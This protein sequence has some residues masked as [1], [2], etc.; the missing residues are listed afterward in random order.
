ML[1]LFPDQLLVKAV[2]EITRNEKAFDR[3]LTKETHMLPLQSHLMNLTESLIFLHGSRLN[4][5]NRVRKVKARPLL[6]KRNRPRGKSTINDNYCVN[7]M[8]GKKN[9]VHVTGRV[10]ILNVVPEIAGQKDCL[11][12]TDKLLCCNSCS[13]CKRV[14]TKER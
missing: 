1:S 5:G 4:T 11:F 9:C 3:Y 2:D 13:F 8:V 10:N 12:V 7:C 14:S 6:I